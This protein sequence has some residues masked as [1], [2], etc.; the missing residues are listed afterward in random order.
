[1][2]VQGYGNVGS[3]SAAILNAMG[4]RVVA[5]SDVSCGLYHPGG[6]DLA[7]VNRH[8]AEHPHHLL[9]GYRGAGTDLITNE[10][11]LTCDAHVLIPAALENQL[12]AQNADAVRA[13]F[14]V[15]G[16]NG[17]STAEADQIFHD[18]GVSVAPDILANAGGVVVS[19]LEWVQDL[20]S[21][22]WTEQEVNDRLNQILVRSFAEV[23]EMSRTKGLTLR[24]TAYLLAVDRVASVVKTR[25]IFP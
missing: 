14:I 21:Y 8:V 5:I 2:A 23:W 16:A 18:R 17:P 1:V 9:E 7:D 19:Y 24:Q 13:R 25:G 10:E 15:E 20:Q 6:L 3:A 11:L 12:H 22:F 4:C